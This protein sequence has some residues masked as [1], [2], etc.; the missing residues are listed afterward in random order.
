MVN[1]RV[2]RNYR[3][4]TVEFLNCRKMGKEVGEHT[5]FKP[6]KSNMHER[7]TRLQ[8]VIVMDRC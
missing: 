2:K 6:T 1:E 4:L 8:P 3:A 7:K 5:D